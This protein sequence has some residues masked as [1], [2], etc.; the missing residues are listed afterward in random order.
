MLEH[1]YDQFAAML[2][3][4]YSLHGK[5]LST[6]AKGL[7]FRA[8]GEF[9]LADFRRALDAHVRDPHR[10]QFPP[11]PA[12]LI[13]QLDASMA[14]DDRPGAEEAWALALT[15]RDEAA[16]VVWTV[17]T[18]QAFAIC[19]PVLETGDEVG[20]RM[21][22]KDAYN[23]LVLAARRSGQ[24]PQWQ[25]SL[26]WDMAQREAILTRAVQLQRLPAP[27]AAALLPA[28]QQDDGYN[29]D[30]A[31][32]NLQRIRSLMGTL[33]SPLEHARRAQEAAAAEERLDMASRK[34]AIAE[35][36]K[37]YTESHA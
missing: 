13:A 23:R 21:A 33:A 37:N 1:D 34:A 16:T 5:S 31:R 2:D 27:T 12:D 36:V 17:E 29:P 22:F 24:L 30:K 20:A 8:M 15:S 10:G 28:P 14:A 3:A 25:A 32:Q 35:Q 26:G 19:R 6:V 9:S 4:V 11:K 7:F 18:A